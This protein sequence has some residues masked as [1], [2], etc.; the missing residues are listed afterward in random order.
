MIY[1]SDQ[2]H[3]SIG[4]HLTKHKEKITIND[5][6]QCD[7]CSVIT[8]GTLDLYLE[9]MKVDSRRELGIFLFTT[10]S[11]PALGPT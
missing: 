6:E 1:K 5:S 4:V 7:I 2:K 8:Y 11:R 9:Y 10:A 3:I